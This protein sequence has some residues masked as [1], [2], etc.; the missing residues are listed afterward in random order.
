MDQVNILSRPFP[1][2]VPPKGGTGRT[3]KQ[4]ASHSSRSG[5]NGK[6]GKG[7]ICQAMQCPAAMARA[8]VSGDKTGI[9]PI[10]MFLNLRT[11]IIIWFAYREFG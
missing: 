5:K 3:G 9:Y 2:P 4:W 7:T 8:M 10:V 1:F 11:Y 6:N